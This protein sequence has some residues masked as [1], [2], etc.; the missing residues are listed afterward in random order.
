MFARL[1][2]ILGRNF[3]VGYLLPALF[4]ILATYLIDS[5]Y[6]FLPK[7][8]NYSSLSQLKIL[9]LITVI[10]LVSIL[11]GIILLVLNGTVIRIMEGYGKFNPF[12][13]IFW[14]EKYRFNK[15]KKEISKTEDIYNNFIDQGKEVSPKIKQK[16]RELIEI[17]VLRFP[18]SK[19]WLLPTSFGNTIRAF[20]TYSRVMY[21]AD[22]IAI[23]SRLLAVI[24]ENYRQ[25]I[26]GAKA[27]VDLWVNFWFVNIILLVI[28][29]V[30]LIYY[31]QLKIQLFPIVCL[32]LIFFSFQQARKSAVGWGNF[33]KSSFDLFLTDLENKLEISQIEN[34]MTNQG[35]LWEEYSQ[36]FLY[37]RPDLLPNKKQTQED[38]R[39]K[40]SILNWVKK[41]IFNHFK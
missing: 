33:I 4:F 15:I 6:N 30:N 2:D 29:T 25:F 40:I 37:I 12:R 7:Y 14:I 41:S 17:R 11:I 35:N 39:N 27:Q 1:P 28:Y 34:N 5:E 23:W 16:Y 31:K 32:F 24:P 8:L 9:E 13:L 3:V 20:E 38:E 18:D 21:G 19:R 36:A 26:E 10:S 22:A